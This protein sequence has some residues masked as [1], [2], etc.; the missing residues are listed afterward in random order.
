[1]AQMPGKGPLQWGSLLG[2][3]D[4]EI[5]S[6]RV[7]VARNQ[8]GSVSRVATEMHFSETDNATLAHWKAFTDETTDS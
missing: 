1:M 7:T 6:R 5:F 4:L 8:G 3:R 2:F